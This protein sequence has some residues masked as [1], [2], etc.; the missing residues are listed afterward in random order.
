MTQLLTL[1]GGQDAVFRKVSDMQRS[2]GTLLG[3]VDQGRYVVIQRSD[4][5]VAVM[6]APAQ[7]NKLLRDAS[8]TEELERE[9]LH[10]RTMYELALAGGPNLDDVC[11]EVDAGKVMSSAEARNRVLGDKREHA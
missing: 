3:E 4:D 2:Y 5:I 7:F 9:A 11:R 8:R 10:W 1:A 6:V